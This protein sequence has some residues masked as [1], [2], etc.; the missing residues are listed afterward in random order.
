M[1]RAASKDAV[2][3][4]SVSLFTLFSIFFRVACTSFGGFMA[5]TSMV[6]QSCVERR[7]LLPQQD[8]VD[9]IALATVLPGTMAVNLIAYVGYRLRGVSGALVSAVA[10]VLPPF[11]FII[12]LGFAYF[13]WGAIPAVGKVFMGFVPAVTAIDR[14]S[15]RLNS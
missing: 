11:I 13:R 3:H 9:G 8:M 15:T 6:Q 5:I 7:R 10:A 4:P 14:K 12:A 1:R 2:S